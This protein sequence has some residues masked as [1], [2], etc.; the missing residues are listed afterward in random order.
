MIKA[1]RPPLV[2]VV[3]VFALA[4]VTPGVDILNLVT[5]DAC[6]T[7]PLVAFSGMARGAEDDTMCVPE[8]ELGRVVIER[9]DAT[10]FGFPVAFVARFPQA[11]LVRIIC[12]MTVKAAPGCVAEFHRLCMTAAALH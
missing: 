2:F 5:G 12:L 8:W 3:A 4:A 9:L 7:D 10:P 6:R 1:N 11:T